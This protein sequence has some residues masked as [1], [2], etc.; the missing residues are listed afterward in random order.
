[1][2]LLALMVPF[3]ASLFGYLRSNRG[4]VA[5]QTG[6]GEEVIGKV[7]TAVEDFF[8]KDEK[9]ALAVMAEVDKARAHDSTMVGHEPPA[10][11]LLRGIVRPLITLTAFVWYVYARAAGVV[12]GGEDY[13]IIGGILAF[14]FGFRPFEKGAGGSGKAATGGR[15][16]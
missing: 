5:K 6:I 4:E 11:A 12:L 1:M 8:S 16:Q 13:A 10:V 15:L 9:A 14:W 7:S 3:F 2:N